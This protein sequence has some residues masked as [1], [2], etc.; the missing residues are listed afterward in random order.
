M[1]YL[2]ILFLILLCA[3]APWFCGSKSVEQY[4]ERF[5][6]ICSEIGM[7]ERP[8]DTSTGYLESSLKLQEPFSTTISS[9]G[10]PPE[11]VDFFRDKTLNISGTIYNGPKNFMW[12]AG[13]TFISLGGPDWKVSCQE[14]FTNKLDG[15]SVRNLAFDDC[16]AEVSGLLVVFQNFVMQKTK[17]GYF[18]DKKNE[19]KIKAD[20]FAIW[21]GA[22]A[23]ALSSRSEA[24]DNLW[25]NHTDASIFKIGESRISNLNFAAQCDMR[26]KS[27][28]RYDM[29]IKAADLDLENTELGAAELSFYFEGPEPEVL[30]RVLAR[31]IRSGSFW[32]SLKEEDPG[33]IL[34][35]GPRLNVNFSSSGASP[36][37]VTLLGIFKNESS[38]NSWDELLQGLYFEAKIEGEAP[39]LWGLDKS[40]NGENKVVI[41]YDQGKF[42]VN[43]KEK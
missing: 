20:N 34:K 25:E 15:G 1:K 4:K 6:S 11:V 14:V 32:E 26:D 28:G 10:L 40:L 33:R 35:S 38:P 27:K 8:F 12:G 37:K 13:R 41:T 21:P 22:A 23:S 24:F 19:T 43:G 16:A 36:L 9:L 29:R 2:I 5:Q 3:L 7:N 18:S 39:A 17:C 42:L 31:T 30:R